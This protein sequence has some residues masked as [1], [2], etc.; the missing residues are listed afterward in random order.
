MA[1]SQL[2]AVIVAAGSSRRMGFDKLT[3]EL[4]GRPLVSHSLAAFQACA[5]VE[6][7]VLVCSGERMAEFEKIAAP[8]AK[9]REVVAFEHDK[10][11]PKLQTND[12]YSWKLGSSGLKVGDR[13]EYWAEAL[14]RNGGTGPG[15]SESRRFRPEGANPL[16]AI[17]TLDT[18]GR[19]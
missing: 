17:A 11:A 18:R 15:K 6:N 5:D 10:G 16:E 7:I 19:G 8:F 1:L 9:V 12:R 2:S 4:L 13:V 14:D 3:A